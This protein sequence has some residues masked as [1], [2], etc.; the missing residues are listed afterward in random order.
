MN[1]NII[2]NLTDR[3]KP[4]VELVGEDGNAFAI[5]GRTREAMRDV[6]WTKAEIA[7]A[8]DEMMSGDYDNLLQTVMDLCEAINH[9]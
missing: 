3:K 7:E 2:R 8:T 9:E 1:Q 6:G 4:H 5:M